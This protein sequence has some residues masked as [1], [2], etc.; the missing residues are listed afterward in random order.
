MLFF[1]S[2]MHSCIVLS[3]E[4]QEGDRRQPIS[5]GITPARVHPQK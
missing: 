2:Q 4:W 5:V 1:A 3:Y